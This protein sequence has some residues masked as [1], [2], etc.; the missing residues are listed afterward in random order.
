MYVKQIYITIENPKLILQPLE[1][2]DLLC[3]NNFKQMGNKNVSFIFLTFMIH[4]PTS[5]HP[6]LTSQT[7][8][9]L[10][11]GMKYCGFLPKRCLLGYLTC[12]YTFIGI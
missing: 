8:E 5:K 7:A 12:T 2:T 4:F 6:N 1:V 11:C 9:S 10:I 3:Q